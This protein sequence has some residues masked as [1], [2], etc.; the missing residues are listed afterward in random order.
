VD[1][2]LA[3]YDELFSKLLFVGVTRAATYL[4]ITC[5]GTLPSKLEALRSHFIATGWTYS[6]E[7]R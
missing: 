2:L 1:D 4:G 3:R 6:V 7:G 5:E